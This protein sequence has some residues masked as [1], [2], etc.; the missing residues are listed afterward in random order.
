MMKQA[1][2]RDILPKFMDLNEMSFKEM[3]RKK[4]KQV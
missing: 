4:R 3:L 2:E 1:A